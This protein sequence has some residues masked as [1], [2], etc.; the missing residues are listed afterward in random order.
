M[1]APTRAPTT[2]T[3]PV[4]IPL[5]TAT[6]LLP[7]LGLLVVA[8]ELAL[9]AAPPLLM[10]APLDEAP[11]VMDMPEVMVLG[12]EVEAAEIVAGSTEV[13]AGI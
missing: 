13:V 5:P 1:A 11:P 2:P 12:A 6:L 10:L 8:A 4:I 7:A 9:E 3:I